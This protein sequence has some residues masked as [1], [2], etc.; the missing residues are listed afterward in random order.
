MSVKLLNTTFLLDEPTLTR[1]V[2]PA[3]ETCF[4]VHPRLSYV[5][6]FN[7]EMRFE[8]NSDMFD[9]ALLVDACRRQSEHCSIQLFMD[10]L[11]YARQDR[12]CV[13]GESLSVKVV[14]DFINSLKFT[15]VYCKDI[16]SAVGV[17]LLDNLQHVPQYEACRAIVN[18]CRPEN[19]VLIS[20]DAGAEKKTF[21]FA[22]NLGYTSIVRA[23]K[24]RELSTGK[25]TSTTLIDTLYGYTAKEFL[26]VDDICDGGRTF[27]ELAKAI[28]A[29]SCYKDEKISLLVTHGIF[30]AGLLP[31][32][33]FV[34]KIYVHNLMN[35]N[36]RGAAVLTEITYD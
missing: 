29:D 22:K 2:F 4:R 12:V 23:S 17:A 16:H 10:Y 35:E 32:D 36:V 21:D 28:K 5:A 20:P 15:A 11:P 1:T 13:E 14:A 24:Q 34:D 33:G 6:E 7:I 27:I 19:T 26:I 8:S 3:G 18:Y 30:S 25:I 9:L 31:F